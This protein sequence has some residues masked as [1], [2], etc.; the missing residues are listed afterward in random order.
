MMVDVSVAKMAEGQRPGTRKCGI[1]ARGVFRNE[2][3]HPVDWNADVMLEGR[4]F[5]ALGL[6]DRIAQTPELL[7]FAFAS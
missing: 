7:A 5:G 2:L 6:R 3:R 4:T 1:E